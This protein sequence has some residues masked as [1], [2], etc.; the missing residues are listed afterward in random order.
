[1]VCFPQGFTEICRTNNTS[2]VQNFNWFQQMCL[3][4][5]EVIEFQVKISYSSTKA[6]LL[7]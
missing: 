6:V 3:D 5:L 2:F 4:E 7:F 1:M